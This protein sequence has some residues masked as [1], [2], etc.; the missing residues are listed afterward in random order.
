MRI[1]VLEHVMD[2]EIA[3]QHPNF[4]CTPADRIILLVPAHYALYSPLDKSLHHFRRYSKKEINTKLQRANLKI[5]KSFYINA[6]GAVG[7]FANGKIFRR[8]RFPSNQLNIF[9]LLTPLLKLEELIHLTFGLS[10]MV[11]AEK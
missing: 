4:L 5:L 3:I 8:K 1:H 2:D 6:L 7:W 10:Q 9:N 11:V